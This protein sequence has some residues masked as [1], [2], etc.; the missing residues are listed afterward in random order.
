MYWLQSLA[1]GLQYLWVEQIEYIKLGVQPVLHL[2]I[3]NEWN[4]MST[5]EA[6]TLRYRDRGNTAKHFDGHVVTNMN[7]KSRQVWNGNN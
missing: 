4:D 2:S 5:S 3:L 7:R 6:F 1:Q